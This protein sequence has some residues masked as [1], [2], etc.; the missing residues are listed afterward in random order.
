MWTGLRHHTGRLHQPH[1]CAHHPGALCALGPRHASTD[2]WHR[3]RAPLFG[4]PPHA[5]RTG[6]PPMEWQQARHKPPPRGLPP[7]D[8]H[9]GRCLGRRRWLCRHSGPRPLDHP[10]ARG[11]R[12]LRRPDQPSPLWRLQTPLAARAP[13]CTVKAT[14]QVKKMPEIA[15]AFKMS[16]KPK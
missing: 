1:P 9:P 8:A 2:L 15:F 3:H 6:H 11:H 7:R 12:P 14:G 5:P 4:P 16:C 10:R 13:T